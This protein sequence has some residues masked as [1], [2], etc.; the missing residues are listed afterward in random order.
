ME[1][2]WKC[3]CLNSD[4][5]YGDLCQYK[6][7]KLRVRE[8]ISK[9]FALIAIAVISSTCAFIII[10]DVLKYVFHIDPVAFERDNYRK[11]CEALRRAKR[12][13]KMHGTKIALRFQYIS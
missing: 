12:P 5:Y 9:S 11:R 4:Y 1:L 8:I 13:I 3:L 7:T 6:T 2:T 10:M